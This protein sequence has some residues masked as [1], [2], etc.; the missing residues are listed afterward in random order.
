MKSAL[1][2]LQV[3]LD[4]LVDGELSPAEYRTLLLALD[5]D[6][7]GWKRCATA[8]L[9]AQAI[10][11]ELSSLGGEEFALPETPAA[12]SARGS[13]VAARRAPRWQAPLGGLIGL[14]A[15]LLLALGLGP[16]LA[17]RQT[18]PAAPTLADRD[19]PVSSAP[20]DA[21]QVEPPRERQPLGNVSLVAGGRKMQ[22]PLF[23]LD[24]RPEALWSEHALPDE[25]LEFLRAQGHQVQHLPEVAPMEL[26]DGRQV[27]VPIDRY[28]IKP[29]HF[30]LVQ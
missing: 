11:G 7:R 17:K 28:R 19:A 10:R 14:A 4:R 3:Q 8:F 30:R 18:P 25:L 22:V 5:A 24:E 6:P 9:E 12:T 1:D 26:D 15:G 2:P 29:A 20:V 16:W 23:A 13:S 27:L 21:P